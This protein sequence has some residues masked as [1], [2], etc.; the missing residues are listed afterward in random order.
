[1]EGDRH[2]LGSRWERTRAAPARVSALARVRVQAIVMCRYCASRFRLNQAIPNQTTFSKAR[3]RR[4]K[5]SGVRETS[6]QFA[7]ELR[8]ADA[9]TIFLSKN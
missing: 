2:W 3:G 5:V 8:V 7:S 6:G 1:M 9:I 4:E